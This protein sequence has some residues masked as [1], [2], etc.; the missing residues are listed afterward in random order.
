MNEGHVSG[1]ERMLK[2][3]VHCVL[4]LNAGAMTLLKSWPIQ[5]WTLTAAQPPT[6]DMEDEE[7]IERNI[8][9]LEAF[10]EA[11]RTMTEGAELVNPTE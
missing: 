8:V 9:G 11:G 3:A 4:N 10:E 6:G 1:S 5:R 7:D 2:F